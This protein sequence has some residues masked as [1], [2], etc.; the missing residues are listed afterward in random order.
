METGNKSIERVQGHNG[1]FMRHKFHH[2]K[3]V[4]QN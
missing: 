1:L 2:A 4:S 3:D